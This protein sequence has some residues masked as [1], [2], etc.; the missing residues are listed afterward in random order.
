MLIK[1]DNL[2]NSCRKIPSGKVFEGLP[3]EG[4][5]GIVHNNRMGFNDDEI[6]LLFLHLCLF[7]SSDERHC[8]KC[9]QLFLENM[10]WENIRLSAMEEL[11]KVWKAQ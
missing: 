2:C 9:W 7:P 11:I 10:R 6:N 4:A 3:L 5:M 8:P 1:A